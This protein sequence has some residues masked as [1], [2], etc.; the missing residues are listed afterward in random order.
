MN[1]VFPINTREDLKTFEFKLKINENDFKCILP[2]ISLLDHVPGQRDYRL[3]KRRIRRLVY[4]TVLH[5]TER[6]QSHRVAYEIYALRLGR[7]S[8]TTS[9]PPSW[10][11]A[12]RPETFNTTFL[13]GP[14]EDISKNT[15]RCLSW[16]T[17][18]MITT[19]TK[20]HGCSESTKKLLNR[21]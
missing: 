3:Y 9:V 12:W 2:T 6:V 7:S 20:K 18:F 16:T 13:F 14:R 5:Q 1:E 19:P 17:Y 4:F 10:S 8:S 21:Y 15:D 11:S